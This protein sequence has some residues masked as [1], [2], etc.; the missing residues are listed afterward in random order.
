[1][2]N[3]YNKIFKTQEEI[4]A[5]ESI[6]AGKVPQA[7]AQLVQAL[8]AD[9]G[10]CPDATFFSICMTYISQVIACIP[11][12]ENDREEFASMVVESILE[13]AENFRK[14]KQERKNEKPS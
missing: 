14:I 6:Y 3:K 9:E 4:S 12:K 11:D 1:M 13:G 5:S 8:C 2:S 10:K 7:I